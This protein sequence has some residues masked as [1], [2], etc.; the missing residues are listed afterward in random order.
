MTTLGAQSVSRDVVG[1][2]SGS[3]AAVAVATLARRGAASARLAAARRERRNG[4]ALSRDEVT[5]V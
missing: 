3:S 1:S 2:G 5:T 4:V